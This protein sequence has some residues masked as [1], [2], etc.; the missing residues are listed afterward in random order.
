MNLNRLLSV[1]VCSLLVSCGGS[2][3]VGDDGPG[4]GDDDSD[5]ADGGPNAGNDDDPNGIGGDD[6]IGDDEGPIGCKPKTCDELGKD[7]G[8]VSDGCGDVIECGTCNEDAACGILERNVCTTIDE[9][10]LCVPLPKE[11]AC[12]G[13]ECGRE[14]D[15]CGGTYNCGTCPDGQQ[16]G[17]LE[18]S[19]CAA[20]PSGGDEGCEAEITSCAD[21]NLQCG[22]TGNGCGG[23]IDC[24]AESGGCA[25]GEICGGG[26][27]QQCGSFDCVPLDPEDACDGSCG[28]VSNGCGVE[29]DDGIIDCST[30]FPCEEGTA[31]G[32]SGVPNVCGDASE[33]CMPL[34]EADACAA[35]EC[36][37]IGDGCE[38]SYDCGSCPAG[39]LCSG[40]TC[41]PL[42][43][44][45]TE[46][47]A[48]MDLECGLVSD[49][50]SG[51]YDCGTCAASERCGAV[52]AFQCDA[53]PP[54]VC[55]PKTP[56]QACA[57][58]ECGQAYDG[59]GDDPVANVIDCTALNGGCPS[60]EFCSILTPF[61]CDAP[62]TPPCTPAASCAALGW[63][64]GVAID[65][66]GTQFNCATEG[67]SCDPATETCIGG[68][69]GPTECLSGVEDPGGS[70]TCDVC[71]SVPSCTGQ[72]QRT[73]ITGR[74]ITPGR[75]DTDTPNQVG[76]SGAFVYIMR[77][78]NTTELPAISTGIPTATD[79]ESCDRC[80]E[81]DLGPVLASATSD[82]FGN[83][84]IE[85]NVPV[86]EQFVLVTK[87]GKWRRAV[88][89]TLPANA[90]CVTT[91]VDVLN[92][93]VPR[94]TSD[95]LAANIPKTAFVTGGVDAMECVFFKIGVAESVFAAGANGGSARMHLYGRDGGQIAA[96][97]DSNPLESALHGD[98]TRMFG[99][100]MLV[101]DCQGAEYP[102]YDDPADDYVRE[103][104]NRGGRMFASHWSYTL[105]QDNDGTFPFAAGTRYDTG[106]SQSADWQSSN[107][108]DTSGTGTISVGRPGANASK[109]SNFS[110]WLDNEGVIDLPS[111]EF[112]I[113]DPRDL[114]TAVNTGAEEFIYRSDED[115]EP[116]EQFA[117]NTPFTAPEDQVCGRVAYSGFH[118]SPGGNA[119]DEPFKG[120]DF[121]GHC[122]DS[123]ANN[124]ALTDQEKVLLYMLFDLGTCVGEE[125]PQPPG[126]TTLDCTGRCGVVSDGC[127]G[128]VDCS[129]PGG[130]LC[131]DSTGVCE[132]P[133]CAASS[134]DAQD[135]ECGYVA[136]GCGNAL[137]C[138]LCPTGE[139]CDPQTNS[140]VPECTP[141][142]A[143]VACADSCGF[144]SDGCGDVVECPDCAGA[145]SCI[146]GQCSDQTCT[147]QECPAN[148]ECGVVSDG[149][150][151]SADCGECTP[152]ETCGGGGE[153]NMCGIPECDPLTCNDQP[154]IECGWTGDG[155]GRAIDCGDC[156]PGQVCG[157]GGPNRCDGCEPRTCAQAN[158]EIPG[159]G[160]L[161]GNIGDGCGEAIDCGDCPEGEICGAVSPNRCGPGQTCTP[162]DCE[163]QDAQ[164]GQI[165]DGCG[166]I[167]DCGP[168]PPGEVCGFETPFQCDPPPP[169]EATTCEAEDAECGA[170]G[171]GCG[172]RIDCGE[173]LGGHTCKNH[174][175]V[176]NSG[177]F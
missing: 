135:A 6:V 47:V 164:C 12:D 46:A 145:L 82:A 65:D 153:A 175:C 167:V 151:G 39:D 67:R 131:N 20:Q 170:I 42:C 169:C 141:I 36:G 28:I 105:L 152:P 25:E 74:V 109:I 158:G 100:D 85:G 2:P 148:L 117:F 3:S 132:A 98:R 58:R 139:V 134:C 14:G 157:A 147:P 18:A 16:C 54:V 96:A 10:T 55:T 60:G 112:D 62:A 8:P 19:Q 52:E 173:C 162:Q 144:I 77:N 33:V 27:P 89:L 129:C 115:S 29:V 64:C 13:I 63:E 103:Y 21:L 102:D 83:Y 161:C 138:G 50:C 174:N 111:L 9:E 171:D 149:C 127:G 123:A 53:A 150:D 79:G 4:A 137:D 106:L 94:T 128:V 78:N 23:L 166:D 17:L 11:D 136:D 97:N 43:T 70:G 37:A 71:D 124:G 30:L 7:C 160:Q 113:I 73:R 41:V 126:C 76:I 1:L 155:C 34:A 172:E 38:G 88:Q 110:T 92:T 118:V 122:T 119:F 107:T 5:D 146:V 61:Q 31:C 59:C 93:R 114:A 91:A 95:G 87:I 86:G 101:F 22:Q 176:K 75:T 66:C 48:C 177:I 40:G 140:C 165:G 35:R 24:D 142:S 168:C 143:D 68:I 51:F 159:T 133:P 26:G 130:Q 81:Q 32:A 49:G 120:D 72:P 116:I 163:M 69:S 121:P 104:V 125:P 15:G 57:G 99:Y 154:D 84:T 44:P 90:A 108:F 45:I 80:E 156:P 56:A